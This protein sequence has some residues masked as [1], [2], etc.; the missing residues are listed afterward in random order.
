[1]QENEKNIQDIY[2]EDEIDLGKLF[3]ELW[4]KKWFITLFTLIITFITIGFLLF[5]SFG[6]VQHYS[7][8]VKI[9]VYNGEYESML[10]NAFN[11]SMF[12]TK[13]KK[14][15]PMFETENIFYEVTKDVEAED[16][17]DEKDEKNTLVEMKIW[18][19]DSSRNRVARVAGF[20]PIILN[21]I[22]NDFYKAEIRKN[23]DNNKLIQESIQEKKIAVKLVSESISA[24]YNRLQE[25]ESPEVLY[26]IKQQ[27]TDLIQ[28][29]T[30]IK[31]Y[32]LTNQMRD[33]FD[34][35][36]MK[37]IGTPVVPD[38]SLEEL[39]EQK[40]IA[41]ELRGFD[42]KK[43]NK[44]LVVVIIFLTSF[45]AAAFFVLITN[46]IKENGKRFSE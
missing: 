42:L 29:E 21:E 38:Y 14:E 15:F 10:T 34:Y 43:T 30:D 33:Y 23:N 45:I 31:S 46:F 39:S 27:I 2:R 40:K 24:N 37:V 35:S 9:K 18:T 5:I 6:E 19:V 4:R 13:I 41:E 12:S 44:R 7:S 22:I 20:V 1:M 25:E 28:R 26:A 8:S 32:I 36:Q 17:K 16:E 11:S 3:F